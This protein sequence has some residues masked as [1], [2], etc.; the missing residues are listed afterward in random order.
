MILEASE[1]DHSRLL[2]IWESAVKATHDFLSTED[3]EFYKSQ[4]P[5]YFQFVSL[6]KYVDEGGIAKGFVGISKNSVE[7]LF[8]DAESRR[9]GIGKELLQFAIENQDIKYVDVNEQNPGGV[10][11][12]TSMGFEEVRRSSLDSEGKKYPII[13]MRI[14]EAK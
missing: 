14:K 8:V 10:E 1:Q 5:A 9:Q 12:Y 2:N 11:F 7:M 3:F 13:H 4:I 6:F